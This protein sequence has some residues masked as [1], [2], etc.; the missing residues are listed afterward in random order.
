M[1]ILALLPGGAESGLVKPAPFHAAL[2]FWTVRPWSSG[3]V[4]Q[5]GGVGVGV[6]VGLGVDVGVGLGVGV[7]VGVG[8]RRGVA[9][10]GGV[11]RTGRGV[12]VGSDVTTP[13]G[14]VVARTPV[15]VGVAVGSVVC[16]G[17]AVSL[18]GVGDDVPRVAVDD[19][20]LML[21]STPPAGR[22]PPAT[23]TPSTMA[24]M[25]RA[26]A[27]TDRRESNLRRTAAIDRRKVSGRATTMGYATPHP[28]HA[29]PA[30]FQ[31]HRQA[32]RLHSEQ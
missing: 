18:G 16:P 8:V 17:D 20:T 31:H 3:T 4:L 25:T 24:T 7:G 10:G 28:G 19:G 13:P 23:V 30:S 12:D 26:A 5:V 9:V 15:R 1:T 2:A 14:A 21:P 22:I 11:T 32:Y 6:G 29:P 27:A